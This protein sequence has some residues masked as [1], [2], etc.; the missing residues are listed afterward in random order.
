MNHYSKFLL[1]PALLTMFACE[2]LK[3]QQVEPKQQVDAKKA[4]QAKETVL[5]EVLTTKK[6]DFETDEDFNKRQARMGEILAQSPVGFMHAQGVFNQ[7]LTS[8]PGNDKALFYSALLDIGMAYQGAMGKSEKL[9]DNPA[10]YQKAV[11]DIKRDSYP[12]ITEF[13]LSFN[14]PK[15]NDY[16]DI[17]KDLLGKMQ[18]SYQKALG[19]LDQVDQ[20]IELIL[21]QIQ[22]DTKITYDCE[23]TSTEFGSETNCAKVNEETSGMRLLPAKRKTVDQ[24]DIKILKGYIKGLLNYTRLYS[25]YSIKGQ[26]HLSNELKIKELE[27][28]RDLT[29]IEE[30]Q[31]IKRYKD[32]LTLDPQ[33]ELSQLSASLEDMV[34]IAMDLESLNNRFCDNDL[35]EMNLIQNICFGENARQSMEE[36]LEMLA[37]PKE[38]YLGDDKQG[39][40]VMILVDL[41]G[42]LNNPVRDLKSIL[43]SFEYDEEGNGVLE[44]EPELN[45][46]FPNRDYLEKSARVNE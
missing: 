39:A 43:A 12:E 8:T 34:A 6:F 21:T 4:S 28:G 18:K 33:N 5:P 26:K 40:P 22:T 2:P 9:W 17:H 29:D 44:R 35:R 10:D 45:G 15:Y 38:I 25:A 14:G 24:E 31:I 27:L 41:P 19:K 1:A 42:Y 3:L 32:Y 23:T 13:L 11:E 30:H 7:V 20:D 46:L 36:T 37:G 16:S